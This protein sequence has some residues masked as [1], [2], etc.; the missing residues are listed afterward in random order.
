MKVSNNN[1]IEVKDIKKSFKKHGSQELLVL[2]HVNFGIRSGE[3]IAILGRSGSGKSTL[4]RI[5]AG[6][7]QPTAGQ[8][9][10]HNKPIEK[11]SCSTWTSWY[12]TTILASQTAHPHAKNFATTIIGTS[13]ILL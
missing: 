11:P 9:L 13:R 4:L 5:I 8:A 12:S 10:Y 2:D 3:I 6:L 1:I 7:I